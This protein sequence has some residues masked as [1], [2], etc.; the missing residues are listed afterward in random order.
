MHRS[1]GIVCSC[2][3]SAVTHSLS[4]TSMSVWRAATGL[5]KI[6]ST[7]LCSMK[8]LAKFYTKCDFNNI[9]SC[10]KNCVRVK[11]IR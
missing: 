7:Y 4:C 10:W 5:P 9:S 6:Y 1:I 11:N 3:L 2:L 8:W